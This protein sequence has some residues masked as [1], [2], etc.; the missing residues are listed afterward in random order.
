MTGQDNIIEL[1]GVDKSFED[2]R[3]LEGIDLSISNGEF[4][5]LLGPSGCGKTTIL[6]ILSGFETP[7]QG[8][9]SIGGQRMND[10]PPE[11]RQVNTVFQNYALFPH[12]T[13]RDNVAFGLRMQSC[14]KGEIEGRVLEALRMVHLEQ[15][16][17]RRPHQLSGGQQQR[18]A[19]ARAVVN[20][21]L[22]LLLDEPFS[23]LDY[24][25]RC[26]MQLEIKRLQ[27]RLGI[28]FVF[29]THDQ[30]EAFAMSDRVVVMN[31]GRIEQIGTPQEIYE[32][33]SNLYVARF[34]GEINI[35]PARI[36]SVPGEGIYIADI[37]GRRF[38]LR[39]SRPFAAGDRVN[40]LLRPEDIRVYAHDDERPEG[41][42]LTGRI[43]ETVY[44]GATVDISIALDSGETLSVAEFFNED[45][46]EISYNRGERVAVTWVDGWEVVLP[47]EAD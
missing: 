24:K 26:A 38:T 20:K 2:T 21:P 12:M 6:R 32:E 40:V 25:L 8:D 18:V 3:A 17:D 45:D 30:E 11:R 15:Y 16:A 10:V 27:R 46:A 44:K 31:Q 19:I 14:P 39:T 1:R 35:L 33:P 23:A 4:L 29:V 22:V 5:T 47:Y 34:V 28:T 7:D 37:S 13:V 43:E 42:Y 36:M 9:V 41:P